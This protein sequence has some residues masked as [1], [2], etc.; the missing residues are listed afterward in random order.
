M[1]IAEFDWTLLQAFVAVADQGSLSGAAR[2]LG[3]SQPT[4]GRQIKTL[5]DSLGQPLFDRH[6][7]GLALSAYGQ[8]LIGPARDMAEAAGAL[9]LAAAG[10]DHGLTGTVRL[11]ASKMVSHYILPPVLAGLRQQFPQ[12]ALEL[13]P[14]DDTENLLFH[15]ADIAIRMYRPRQLDMVTRH[16]GDLAL[17][18]FAA[19]GYL[20]RHGTPATLEDLMNHQMVGFDRSDL[21]L[22]G[23]REAGLPID[24]DWFPVRCDDQL[25]YWQLVRAGCGIGVT[26]LSLGLPDPQVQR[27]LPALPL[28]VLP[29]WL[30]AHPRMR[31][32]ARVDRV[33]QALAEALHQ[34]TRA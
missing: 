16:V 20:D 25:T 17:G 14:T 32:V 1:D 5:E 30:T 4:L 19:H 27:V 13:A 18:F 29:V 28:P 12:I 9:S 31:A 22:S 26:Q 10:Q 2:A 11:T 21:L 3:R 23:L 33:W 24:R 15:E 7:R 6:P 8:S 34:A